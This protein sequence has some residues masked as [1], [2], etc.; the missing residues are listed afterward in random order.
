MA[1]QK[2]HHYLMGRHFIIHIDK[3]MFEILKRSE[4][5][6]RQAAQMDI[7]IDEPEL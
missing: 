1:L 3:K 2:W 7:Q 4:A 5:A 6:G